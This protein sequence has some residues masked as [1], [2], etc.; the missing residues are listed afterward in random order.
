M[1]LRF[2]L[3]QPVFRFCVILYVMLIFS[4][5]FYGEPNSAKSWKLNLI[6]GKFIFSQSNQ[7]SSPSS[8][9]LLDFRFHG[10]LHQ[11]RAWGSGE[12]LVLIL[13][14]FMLA[15]DI[16][17][18]VCGHCYPFAL[19]S[20]LHPVTLDLSPLSILSKEY[21]LLRL[22]D[23]CAFLSDPSLLI[24]LYFRAACRPWNSARPSTFQT[25]QRNCH[26]T[27]LHSGIS[28][29]NWWHIGFPMSHMAEGNTAS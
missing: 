25:P 3:K 2:E 28:G 12:H 27:S 18:S 1:G 29:H 13:H 26:T 15:L 19:L 10:V 7:S 17:L 4:L 16:N 14:Q 20:I 6:C 11:V 23:L 9:S 22:R 21:I 24:H 8:P 5:H